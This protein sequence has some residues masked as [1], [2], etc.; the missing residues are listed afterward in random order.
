[1][2]PFR[3]P[4]ARVA[5]VV[6]S[7]VPM[8]APLLI[9]APAAA[10]APRFNLQ[11]D[12]F[13]D[14]AQGRSYDLNLQFSPA[15]WLTLAI[16]AGQSSSSLVATDFDG[17]S[18][19]GGI[20]ARRGRFS[21][22]LHAS[23]WDDSD[24]FTSRIAGGRLAVAFADAFEAGLLLESR[25]LEVGYTATGLLG[26]TS[27]QKVRFD[28]SGIGA[29]LGWYGN[30]WSGYLRGV[31]YDYDDQLDRVISASRAPSTRAFPR[32]ASLLTSVLTRTAGAIDYQASLGVDRAFARSG[33]GL[34]L[35]L[36]SDA[37]TGDDSTS[38]SASWRYDLN[39]RFGV[40]ATLGLTETDGLD[41]IGFAGLGFSFRN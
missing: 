40:Q 21:G 28:G 2:R 31:A 39:A 41:S 26:R 30:A 24:Q 34:D 22:G 11:A 3:W 5:A 27:R 29:E 35:M 10:A 17:R 12:A 16:G 15:D 36:S 18:V 25:Q 7:L 23:Q 33:L 9:A 32:V 37:I 38:L 1:M 13:V 19:H 20:D 6:S 8:L 4:A 14:D